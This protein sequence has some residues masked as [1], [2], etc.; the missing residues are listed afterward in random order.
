MVEFGIKNDEPAVAKIYR[1]DPRLLKALHAIALLAALFGIGLFTVLNV[2]AD[3]RQQGINLVA[4][5]D[6]ATA[7]TEI[8]CLLYTSDAADE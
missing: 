4:N 3:H 2:N 5:V 8:L 7:R 1:A 6:Q